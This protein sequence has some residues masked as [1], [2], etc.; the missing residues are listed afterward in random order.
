MEYSVWD[1]LTEKNYARRTEKFAEQ[2]LK[3]KIKEK[4]NEIPVA[5]ICK[6]IYSW[7]K[8]QR[9][10]DFEDERRIDHILN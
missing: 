10:V 4:W 7:E 5:K 8:R 1:S 9:L 2:E 3:H 6:S